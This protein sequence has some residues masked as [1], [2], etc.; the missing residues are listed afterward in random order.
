M[1][2]KA[3]IGSHPFLD[4]LQVRP[5]K[6]TIPVFR[7]TGSEDPTLA[8]LNPNSPLQPTKQCSG[9]RGAKDSVAEL[10]PCLDVAFFV[11]ILRD[12]LPMRPLS[13]E[14]AD[15]PLTGDR[16]RKS[17]GKTGDTVPGAD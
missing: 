3:L 6:M 10:R 9:V 12:W 2:P 14:I 16:G 4:S 13:R 5:R 15:S 7:M 11:G 8:T 1:A 17:Q